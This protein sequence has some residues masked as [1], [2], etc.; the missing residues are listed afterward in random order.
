[1]QFKVSSRYI[2]FNTIQ[3]LK[4]NLVQDSLRKLSIEF[5]KTK[6]VLTSETRWCETTTLSNKNLTCDEANI[7]N[8]FRTQPN[9]LTNI[10]RKPRQHEWIV[11]PQ[12]NQR[13]SDLAVFS[14]PRQ[15]VAH[16]GWPDNSEQQLLYSC[17]HPT[18]PPDAV[19]NL[20]K[21]VVKHSLMKT[22]SNSSNSNKVNVCLHLQLLNVEAQC[23]PILYYNEVPLRLPHILHLLNG[24][25]H[26]WPHL[27]FRKLSFRVLI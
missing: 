10:A 22:S 9:G 1:M 4:R 15:D 20:Q 17:L 24:E 16:D 2:Q 14:S 3:L 23:L 12:K 5:S 19:F 11:D 8:D 7:A 18:R 26:L 25:L 13:I 27:S 21:D 6:K